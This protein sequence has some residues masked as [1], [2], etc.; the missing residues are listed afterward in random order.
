ML[1]IDTNNVYI[2]KKSDDHQVI[3]KSIVKNLYN[4]HAILIFLNSD[5]HSE[6]CES[7]DHSELHVLFIYTTPLLRTASHQ[8]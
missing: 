4:N 6:K 5:I 2:K 7:D 1:A 3:T 8:N